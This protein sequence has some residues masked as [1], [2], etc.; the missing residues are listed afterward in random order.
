MCKVFPY[1]SDPA[2]RKILI[3][4]EQN[5]SSHL[6]DYFKEPLKSS[7]FDKFIKGKKQK[8]KTKGKKDISKEIQKFLNKISNKK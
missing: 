2:I 1:K 3:G 6:R 5:D 8:H 4:L 7:K